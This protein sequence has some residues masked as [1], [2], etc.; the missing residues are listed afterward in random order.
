[1]KFLN[2]SETILPYLFPERISINFNHGCETN[3]KCYPTVTACAVSISIPVHINNDEEIKK[4]FLE[5]LSLDMG[6]GGIKET[7]ALLEVS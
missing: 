4:I 3:C 6:F 1:M 2:G 5:A 7:R